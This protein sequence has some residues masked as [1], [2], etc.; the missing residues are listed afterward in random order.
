MPK[1]RFLSLHY[2]IPGC[3]PL[4]QSPLVTFQFFQFDLVGHPVICIESGSTEEANRQVTTAI[5]DLA[6]TEIIVAM[7]DS[8]ATDAEWQGNYQIDVSH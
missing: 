4:C 1:D 5:Q 2:S 8:S 6:S 7:S 3:I